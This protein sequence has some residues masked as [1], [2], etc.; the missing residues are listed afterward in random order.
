M[1]TIAW[2]GKKTIAADKQMNFCDTPVSAT[3][4][5]KITY[6]GK[7]A[8]AAGSGEVAQYTPVIDWIKNQRKSPPILEANANFGVIVVTEEGIAYVYASALTPVPISGRPW[9]IGTGA[10]YALGAMAFGASA[11]EAVKIASA[12]DVNTGLGIDVET[13]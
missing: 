8:V 10:D 9:A 11:V 12:L 4:L 3:K 1:T 7:K 2:D 6:K 13:L 5:V